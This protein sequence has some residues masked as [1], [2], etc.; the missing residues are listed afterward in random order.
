MASSKS[1][2][3]SQKGA[4]I[5]PA[6]ASSIDVRASDTAIL[7]QYPTSFLRLL[8]LLSPVI[9]LAA[10]FVRLM[11]WS[12]GPGT[13]SHSFLLVLGWWAT[14]LYGYEMLR[15]APQAAILST[16]GFNGLKRA[17]KGTS[18]VS[19][20]PSGSSNRIVSSDVINATLSDLTLLADF[21]ST[22][23]STILAPLSSMLNWGN[24]SETRGFA[25]FLLT[26]WPLW[27]LCFSRDVWDFLGLPRVG[28]GLGSVL[29]N[30]LKGI[31]S[32]LMPHVTTRS[33][34]Y[35]TVLREKS[36]AL[37]QHWDAV[38]TLR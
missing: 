7:T 10:R 38:S 13:A 19:S 20:A 18:G 9:S 33:V 28:L 2:T 5:D 17:F 14:C 31:S 16:I 23:A 8:V 27:L 26:S 12:G 34:A 1:P 11:T 29:Q 36:P 3:T 37:F 25:I 6:S 4:E 22:L 15:Y 30:A 35:T 32:T 24:P 21:S